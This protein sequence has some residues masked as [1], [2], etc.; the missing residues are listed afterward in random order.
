MFLLNKFVFLDSGLKNNRLAE[1]LSP[2]K[3]LQASELDVEGVE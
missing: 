2:R 3:K 1:L